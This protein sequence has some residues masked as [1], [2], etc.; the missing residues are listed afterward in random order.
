[1]TRFVYIAL[2]V[3]VGLAGPRAV[4]ADVVIN[5]L[6]YHPD[7]ILG[8]EE[9]IELYNPGDQPIDLEGWC[10]DGV[11]FCFSGG[12]Q[13]PP[14]EYL[15]LASDAEAFEA[16]YGFPPD[17]TY[18]GK[19]DNGGETLTLSDA[20][21]TIVDQVAFTDGS[22]G[23][24]VLPD[25][26]GPSL[27]VIDAEQDNNLPRNW[28]A[29]TNAAGHTAGA[30]NSVAG[31]GLPPWLSEVSFAR[32]PDPNTPLVVTVRADDADTVELHYVFQ[33]EDETPVT[34]FD[35]GAHDDGDAD[36]GIYGATIP[37]Q[38]ANTLVRF[39][40]VATGPTGVMY[41]PRDDDTVVYDGTAVADPNLVSSLPI[42]AWYMDPNDYQAAVDH[43]DTDETEPAVLVYDGLL[44][45]SLEVRVRG[46]WSR[47]WPKKHW[48]MFFPKGH[49]FFAPDLLEVP[50]REFDLQAS[51]GDK[52]YLR[53][54]LAMDGFRDAG[55]PWNVVRP[56]RLNQNGEFFGLYMF[57]ESMEDEWLERHGL[58]T[59]GAWYKAFE[60]LRFNSLEEL[61]NLYEKKTRLHEDYTDLFNLVDG[62]NTL[63]GQDRIDFLFDNFDLPSLLNYLAVTCIIHNND[64]VKKNYYLYRDTEGTQRWSI[65][66]Y[67]LDLT[68][69]RNA[70]QGGILNDLIWADDDDVGREDVSPSH[71]LFGDSEHQKWHRQWN[72]LIDALYETPR[73]RTMY[74]RRL[75]SVMDVM[76]APD[77]LEQRIDALAPLL[78]AEAELDRQSWGQYGQSQALDEAL[79]VL[80]NDYLTP[81]R[82]HLLVTH[83][84]ADQIPPAPSPDPDIVINEIMYNPVDG[85]EAEYLELHNLAPTESTDLSGWRL[86]GVDFVFPSGTV[87]LPDDYLVLVKN[88][89]V[90]R[91]AYGSG[92]YVAGQYDGAL[93][94]GGENLTLSDADGTII[95]SVRFDDDAPWPISPDAGGPSLELIDPSR[96]HDRPANWAAS[97]AAGGTPGA[98]N[99]MA[100]TSP[101]VPNLWV[102][103]VLPINESVN[104]DELGEYEPWIELYNASDLAMDVGGMFLTDD[105]D[106][107]A[108]WAIPADS[109][110]CSGEWLLL[111]ADAEPGDGPQHANF[112]LNPL[113][114]SVGLYT[115]GGVIVD[116]LNYG[117]LPANTSYGKFP[118]GT[119]LRREFAVATPAA[120]NSG[121]ATRV[122][123]NEY[124]AVSGTHLLKD[125]GT[126]TF[127]GRIEG[128]GGDWFEL[129]VTEDHLDLRGWELVVSDDTGGEDES[130]E[131]L[132]L[133]QDLLWSDLRSGTIITV[134]E[135]LPNDVSYDPVGGDW[136]IN[137]RAANSAS[138]IYITASNFKV[139]NDDWQLTIRDAAGQ[140]VFGPAGEGVEPPGGVGSNEIARLEEHPS[141]AIVPNSDYDD[142]VESTFGSPN[143]IADG[144]LA[145]DFSTLQSVVTPCVADGECDDGDDCTTDTCIDG[146]CVHT[147]L[148]SCYELTLS[149]DGIDDGEVPVCPGNPITILLEAA[150]VMAPVDSVRVLLDYD[151]NALTLTQV[152]AG[153]GNGSPWDAASED[154]FED[155]GGAVAYAALL[156]EGA[157]MA[158]AVVA[159]F[160]FDVIGGGG[161]HNVTFRPDCIPFPTS[162]RAA[163]TGAVIL[164]NTTDTGDFSITPGT[165]ENLI[166]DLE[167]GGASAAEHTR[168]LT[169]ELYSCP[170]AEPV[171]VERT[172]AF[173]GGQASGIAVEV[174]CGDYTCAAVRDKLHTL[175]RVVSLPTP[176]D[177][178]TRVDL[179]GANALVGG[180]VNDDGAVDVLD[181]AEVLAQFGTA[182]GNGD[183]DCA[184]V[185]PHVDLDGD[186][187]V[188]VS[189]YSIVAANFLR[190][191]DG[192]CCGQL[193][194]RGGDPGAVSITV[195]EPRQRGFANSVRAVATG[196]G[197][198][199]I[200]DLGAFRAKR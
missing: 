101:A 10:F 164:A 22:G 196:D 159:R 179:T 17:F 53:E 38:P 44:Y 186:G 64:H 50:V 108:M 152:T 3:A 11:Q 1:M 172:V 76:L 198:N 141:P 182:L 81:R 174:P 195:A 126:D 143:V 118:E 54:L 41:Y 200:R 192:E 91:A 183:T 134:S 62:L 34:M 185:G 95:D 190:L 63:T 148:S 193:A 45:D 32:A 77:Q 155:V 36:D 39:R 66:A 55:A 145:Q 96:D 123:L 113:G 82:T 27:E 65:H 25:G 139:S 72:H 35:D 112:A 12:H 60:D 42:L 13:I 97:M 197:L 119:P 48:K 99:S 68:W 158:D 128:N 93:D 129:V 120:S 176:G 87:L 121:G 100:G 74:Y 7:S 162:L 166:F 79:S 51:Y 71:P 6:M 30:V 178:Q 125:G 171:I 188:F 181:L 61:P 149:V 131:S 67:D 191:D 5:E 84:I 2:V 98:A 115:D 136:W 104:S 83:R 33:F 59:H 180:D 184:T 142:G 102:N 18:V 107:P 177:G 133:T 73:I 37:G 47:Q 88:D 122:I 114:G 187:V 157:T 140:V 146:A 167:I 138:G 173:V 106:S 43:Y 132:F 28:H 144:G 154:F 168:C 8:D 85:I 117:P 24:P 46:Q 21:Q 16:A 9:F 169:F 127:W 4:S 105:Y 116:Y 147:P 124:N 110:V 69:G 57:R 103:E 151:P 29:S 40:I 175:R 109:V 160:T 20:E 80:E 137:V 130:I 165:T 26:E 70:N 75:R 19:L 161:L 194:A 150:A 89:V 199:N 23:W 153:D 111:W 156:P 31:T 135:D 92:I 94:N 56:V 163:E 86:N 78:A 58:D 52:S 49:K 170:D 90:F 15:V 14:G 189:D